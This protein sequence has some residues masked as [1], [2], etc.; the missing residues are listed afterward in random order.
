M[1]LEKR[2][3]DNTKSFSKEKIVIEFIREMF[4]IDSEKK[5]N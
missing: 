2:M 3:N 4:G 1:L 5:Q